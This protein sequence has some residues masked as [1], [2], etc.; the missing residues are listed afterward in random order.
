MSLS[1]HHPVRVPNKHFRI[2]DGCHDL[3]LFTDTRPRRIG[4]HHTLHHTQVATVLDVAIF[5]KGIGDNCG[6]GFSL[7]ADCQ[8]GTMMDA[9]PES[10]KARKNLFLVGEQLHFFPSFVL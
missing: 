6:S 3:S 4:L 2:V 10:S 5:E 7:N 9:C 8:R 1:G